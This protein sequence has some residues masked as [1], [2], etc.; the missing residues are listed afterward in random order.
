MRRA[1]ISV[2]VAVSWLA[3][4]EVRAASFDCKKAKTKIEKLICET[5]ELSKA[6]DDL[7]ALF[8]QAVKAVGKTRAKGLRE[9]QS[10]WL[11]RYRNDCAD[12][13]CALA[14]YQKRLLEL[15]ATIKPSGRSGTYDRGED[16]LDVLEVAPGKLRFELMLTF[17]AG[18]PDSP[19]GQLCGEVALDKAG[20]G[21]F[22]EEDCELAFSFP[23]KGPV[24]LTQKG[25]CG[26][27][28]G[29]IADGKYARSGGAM[30]PVFS[31]CYRY[32]PVDPET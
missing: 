5:P 32:Q 31:F 19:N 27:G 20:R 25:G 7:G 10:L 4:A 2:A 24:V 23:A 8:K 29:V 26:F 30:A 1:M 3:T 9:A 16:S 6:D 22:A 18:N 14:A 21:T 12:A 17:E 13:A 11:S 15:R 28:A